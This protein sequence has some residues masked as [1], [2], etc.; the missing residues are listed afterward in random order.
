MAKYQKQREL[1]WKL[2]ARS[3]EDVRWRTKEIQRHL[4]EMKWWRTR[5][6]ILLPL[7]IKVIYEYIHDALWFKITTFPIK[8]TVLFYLITYISYTILS[9][10]YVK[11]KLLC[12]KYIETF[13]IIFYHLVYSKYN[14]WYTRVIPYFVFYQAFSQ[15]S[16]STEKLLNNFSG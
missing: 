14:K 15:K 9:F 8:K 1:F 13:I 10:L 7:Y 16:K 3:Y 5:L 6:T 11:Q 4:K 2:C 12:N